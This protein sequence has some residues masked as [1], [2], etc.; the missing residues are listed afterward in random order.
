MW[1][2]IIYL[3]PQYQETGTFFFTWGCRYVGK[4]FTLF[5]PY[6]LHLIPFQLIPLSRSMSEYVISIFNFISLQFFIFVSWKNV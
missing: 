2:L 5:P 3:Q 1:A 4:D 6:G